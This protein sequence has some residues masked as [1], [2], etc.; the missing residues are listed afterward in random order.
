MSQWSGVV[1]T[2]FVVCECDNYTHTNENISLLSKQIVHI[3]INYN[4][5]PAPWPS[6]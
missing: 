5:G 3:L 6:G 1:P 2:S 4:F